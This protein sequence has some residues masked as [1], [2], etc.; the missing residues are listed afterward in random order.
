MSS[1]GSTFGTSA[2]GGAG[3]QG[4]T[5]THRQEIG[6]LWAASG[7]DSEYGRLRSVLLHRPGGELAAALDDPDSVQM[8]APL[9]IARAGEQHDAMAEAYRAA[10][11]A[12]EYVEPSG[13]PTP[14]QMF[15]ADLFVMTPEGAIL[16][17]PAS[18][19]RAGEER[20]VARRLADM[21]VPILRTLTG[22]AVF[23][24]ADLMWVDPET[25]M[26][27]LGLRT[28]EEAASQIAAVLEEVGIETLAVDIPYGTM[29]FMGMLRIV[30]EDL[31]ICWPR[32]TPFAA[33]RALQERGHDIVWLPDEDDNVLNRALNVVTLGPRRIL[34]L[35]GYP[36]VQ[37]VYEAAGIECVTVDGSELV[38]AA[39]A[40]G[41]LTGVVSRDPVA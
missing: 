35:A 34:M 26:I 17:R 33:V 1:S 31:A 27:G 10:G 38:K 29:H 25:V 8:L 9:D 37:K 40:I 19:V 13:Q 20:W 5:R 36:S 39:G 30:D 14:N 32:R 18:T 7:I 28:N 4:R 11:V 2:Y 23:E 21:G 12:V 3:W 16:A 22:N 24:G 15:C 6:D 41:C